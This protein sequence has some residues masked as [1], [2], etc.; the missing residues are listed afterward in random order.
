MRSRAAVVPAAGQETSVTTRLSSED[1]RQRA[2]LRQEKTRLRDHQVAESARYQQ[3][4]S[5]A[6]AA[7]VLRL[8]ELRLARETEERRVAAE[9]A[10]QQASAPKRSHKAKPKAAAAEAAETAE[11]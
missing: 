10:A 2:E 3:E 4:Q 8:R 7:K 1:A 6:S 9:R 11:A 5:N